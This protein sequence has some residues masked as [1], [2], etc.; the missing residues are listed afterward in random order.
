MR[1]RKQRL[2]DCRT[3]TALLTLHHGGQLKKTHS[4]KV[5]NSVSFGDLPEDLSQR[6]ASEIALRSQ[7]V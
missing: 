1:R 3:L 2:P 7:G 5:E 6:A 4:L